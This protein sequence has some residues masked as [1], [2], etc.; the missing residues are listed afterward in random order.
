[1][2]FKSN[3]VKFIL[4]LLCLLFSSNAFALLEIEITQGVES[5]MPLAITPVAGDMPIEATLLESVVYSDLHRSGYFSI[6]DKKSYPQQTVKLDQVEYNNWR[7]I[8]IEALLTMRATAVGEGKVRVQ[9]ELYDL[10]RKNRALGHS[11]TTNKNQLRKV[12]HKISDLV[13]EKLTGIKGAF[14]TRIAYISEA[15][16][17]KGKKYQLQIADA[18]GYNPRTIFSSSKQ[19]LSPAWSPDG[20]RLAYVS[21]E[22][23][24]TEIFVQDITTGKRSKI[25]SEPGINSAPAWSPDGGTIA[26]TLSSGGDPE[27]YLLDVESRK[28]RK[29][30]NHYGIDTEPAWSPDGRFIYFTSNRSGAP[31]IYQV[32][33]GGGTP[34]R[35]TFEGNYNAA[36]SVS[37]DGK[38]L[39]MVHRNDGGYRIGLLDIEKS[40]FRLLTDGVLDEAPSFAPNGSM[41][42]YSTRH[43]NSTVLSA[44]SSDGR[45]RQRLRLQKEKVR[46]PSWSPFRR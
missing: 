23:D 39:A 18:D 44:V 41:I 45:V 11:V 6:V 25:S 7:N 15:S 34:K 26:L 21:F 38:Y 13:F 35:V 42:I 10:V 31:Q 43:N 40:S 36:P 30:T 24:R 27:I 2:Y 19:L 16:S 46:E 22:N 3:S 28:L 20:R 8:G 9:F 29:L 17:N 1:M 33:F 4:F 12:A 37:A 14:S 5:A 32:S